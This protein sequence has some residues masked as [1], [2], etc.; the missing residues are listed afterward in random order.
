MTSRLITAIQKKGDSYHND[1]DRKASLTK[2]KSHGDL[3]KHKDSRGIAVTGPGD[4]GSQTVKQRP[5]AAVVKL[6][7]ERVSGAGGD[8]SHHAHL[9][10][11]KHF[12][13]YTNKQDDLEV[14]EVSLALGGTGDS[15]VSGDSGVVEYF[16]HGPAEV[17]HDDSDYLRTD[18]DEYDTPS[19]FAMVSF[20]DRYLL[21]PN[22]SEMTKLAHPSCE[23]IEVTGLTDAEKVQKVKA[24]TSDFM[25]NQFEYM[26]CPTQGFAALYKLHHLERECSDVFDLE[27]DGADRFTISAK[28]HHFPQSNLQSTDSL[29]F[30]IAP[31]ATIG[32]HGFLRHIADASVMLDDGVTE[33]IVPQLEATPVKLRIKMFNKYGQL[34]SSHGDHF[35][36]EVLGDKAKVFKANFGVKS[37]VKS[38]CA[39][40]ANSIDS[41]LDSLDT[42]NSVDRTQNNE[43]E[44][45]PA[46]AT[47][48]EGAQSDGYEVWYKHD[49]ISVKNA[50]TKSCDGKTLIYIIVEAHSSD[51]ATGEAGGD[52][53]DI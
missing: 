27:K 6:S 16:T 4:D 5:G 12:I 29:P 22:T 41:L 30:K 40:D 9:E 25:G 31:C 33:Y 28:T 53:P 23:S 7:L 3:S 21:D 43:S 13:T 51:D 26:V 50:K 19:T 49:C 38:L 47:E 20:A 45:A 37:F 35:K 32:V 2:W 48:E 42:V 46:T 17:R 8:L 14:S 36:I 44:K 24:M 1:P 11:M 10:R 15:G 39:T 52:E 34:C 18:K